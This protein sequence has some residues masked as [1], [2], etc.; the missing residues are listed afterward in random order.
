LLD[1]AWDVFALDEVGLADLLVV[2]P[3]RDLTFF[4]AIL[5]NVRLIYTRRG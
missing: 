5:K 3:V 2:R 1:P 4:R